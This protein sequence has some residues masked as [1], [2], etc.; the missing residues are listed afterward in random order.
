MFFFF[1]E[2]NDYKKNQFILAIFFLGVSKNR[3]YMSHIT[4]VLVIAAINPKPIVVLL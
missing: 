1:K 4:T 3:H 2:K